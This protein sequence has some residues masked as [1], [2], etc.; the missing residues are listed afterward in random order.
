MTNYIREV[1]ITIS[2]WPWVQEKETF[3][4]KSKLSAK[5]II[6]DKFKEFE[7]YSEEELFTQDRTLLWL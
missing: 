5:D 3:R 6:A 2:N 1:T 4:I 7:K